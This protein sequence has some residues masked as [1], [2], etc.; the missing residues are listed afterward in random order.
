MN[1]YKL[2]LRPQDN[3]QLGLIMEALINSEVKFELK[4]VRQ[5]PPVSPPRKVIRKKRNSGKWAGRELP[6]VVV[7]EVVDLLAAN[8]S[9]RK[10]AKKIGIS[11]TSIRHIRNNRHPQQKKGQANVY[12]PF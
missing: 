9:Y 5:P 3:A 10:I 4:P 1:E 8:E 7:N 12:P 11:T 2:T 6:I